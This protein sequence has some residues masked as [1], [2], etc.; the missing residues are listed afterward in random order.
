MVQ[1]SSGVTM[2]ALL[3]VA[4][5]IAGAVL[6]WAVFGRNLAGFA[7]TAWAIFCFPAL[8]STVGWVVWFSGAN[9]RLDRERVSFGGPR[10]RPRGQ[11]SF[12]AKQ[13]HRA[14]W[15]AVD[16]V[17]IVDGRS[18]ARKMTK[19]SRPRFMIKQP[20]VLL[21]YYPVRWRR[22]HLAF[23]VDLAS[24]DVPTTRRPRDSYDVNMRPSRVWVLPVRNPGPVREF[25]TAQ[26]VPFLETT[27]PVAPDFDFPKLP[28]SNA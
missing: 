5:A 15:Q 9:L 23:R 11:V 18:A 2:L 14:P 6:W 8:V 22:Y 21:G 4:W 16:D 3:G 12:A 19:V 13:R 20:S 27:D 24:A 17:Q 10:S 25:L 26:G 28:G 1:R 7:A